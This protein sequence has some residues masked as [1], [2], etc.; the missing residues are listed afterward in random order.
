MCETHFFLILFKIALDGHDKS[1]L[2]KKIPPFLLPM[3]NLLYKPTVTNYGNSNPN[4][5][6]IKH[7]FS[8][9]ND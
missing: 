1:N 2:Q 4:S 7:L 6:K 8:R 5:R 9:L 3:S